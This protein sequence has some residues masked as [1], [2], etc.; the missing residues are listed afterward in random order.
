MRLFASLT[1]VALSLSLSSA[2]S[3]SSGLTRKLWILNQQG[4]TYLSDFF[5]CVLG[6]TNWNDLANTYSAGETIV[7]GGMVQRDDAPCT[8]GV[9]STAFYQCAVNAGSFDV[10]QYDVLL[11]VIP[12]SGYGG[13]NGAATVTNPKSGAS[14]SINVAFV[15]TSPDPI[16]QTIYGGHEVFEAQT[17]G[18]SADCCDGETS[19]GGPMNGCSQC[20]PYENGQGACGQYAGGGAIGT[21]GIA[22]IAC[23]NATY[24][25][26]RVSP[27]S[28]EFDGTCDAITPTVTPNNPCANVSAAQSGVYCGKSNQNGFAGGSPNTLYDCENGWVASTKTCANGCF[29]APSGQADGCNASAPLD[30]GAAT[31]GAAAAHDAATPHP[32]AASGSGADASAGGQ[33]D[34]GS[35]GPSGTGNPGNQGEADGGAN[36]ASPGAA[37]GE[38]G[39]CSAG[40]GESPTASAW[41][42]AA[43]AIISS[44]LRRRARARFSPAQ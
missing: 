15:R 18:V 41:L 28:H 2:A 39:G 29:I 16:Y 17:D 37:S 6:G 36:G 44:R 10:A 14:V 13:Q 24:H 26:Q 23:P 5:Q 9:G 25:Y 1:I 8:G 21:L 42:V 19:T 4:A 35:G 27:A 33:D 31:D 20:G 30:A 7:F 3:A 40:A 34:A 32:D 38:S 11:V 22:T 12:D 43:A